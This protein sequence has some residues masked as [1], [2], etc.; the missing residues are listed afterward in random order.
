M[1]SRVE[2]FAAVRR[3]ARVEGLSIRELADK[4]HVHRRMVRQAFASAVPPM[5]KSPKPTSPR[6]AL[7]SLATPQTT[8]DP[9]R[10]LIDLAVAIADGAE[11]ISDI[12]TLAIGSTAS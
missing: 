10:V 7:C 1:E 4:H 9:G 11:C 6:S 5:R 8:H 2:L 12:T 3:D